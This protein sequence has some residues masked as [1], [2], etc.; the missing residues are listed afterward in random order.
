MNLLLWYENYDGELPKPAILKP[1]P[2]WT[3]KQIISKIIPEV[4]LEKKAISAEKSFDAK[5][6]LMGLEAKYLDS[7]DLNIIIEKG[8]LLSGV[9]DKGVVGSTA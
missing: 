8:E 6:R 7:R 5:E 2:L 1:Y 3:G 9:L 4:N